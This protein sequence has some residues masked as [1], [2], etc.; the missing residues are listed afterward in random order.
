MVA[1]ST[2]RTSFFTKFCTSWAEKAPEIRDFEPDP[3]RKAAAENHQI[4]RERP[5][6]SGCKPPKNA[7]GV[8]PALPRF[9]ALVIFPRL[10]TDSD[11]TTKGQPS[12]H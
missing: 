7:V 6:F 8:A 9:V 5:R 4:G 2:F 10:G 11:F 1:K 3:K 12:C